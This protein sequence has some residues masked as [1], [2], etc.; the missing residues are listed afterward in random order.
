MIDFDCNYRMLIGGALVAGDSEIEVVNPATGASFASAPDAT[1][2]QLDL[3]VDAATRAFPGWK[4]LSVAERGARLIEAGQAI[5]LNAAPLGSLFT[6]EQGRPLM[7]ALAEITG[8]ADWLEQT[9][10]KP[11]NRLPTCRV[12]LHIGF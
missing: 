5:R 8:A 11:P 1:S 10:R 4:A 9:S 7:F 3:A 12:Q 6:R 2:A